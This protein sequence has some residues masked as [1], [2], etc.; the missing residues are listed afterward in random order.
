MNL[1]LFIGS[2]KVKLRIKITKVFFKI[3]TRS[4]KGL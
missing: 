3:I 2:W 4:L 1:D